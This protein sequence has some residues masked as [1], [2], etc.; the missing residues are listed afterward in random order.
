MQKNTKKYI[1]I[2]LVYKDD[3]FKPG[4]ITRKEE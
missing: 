1:G 2:F 3:Y 4:R